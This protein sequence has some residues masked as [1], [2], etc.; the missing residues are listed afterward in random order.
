MKGGGR[1]WVGCGVVACGLAL[2]SGQKYWRWK[3][4]GLV[5]GVL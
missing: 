3:I 2:F 1:K 5:F 4:L